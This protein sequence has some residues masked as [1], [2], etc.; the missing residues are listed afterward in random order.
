MKKITFVTKGGEKI[1]GYRNGDKVAYR[2]MWRNNKIEEYFRNCCG[3]VISENTAKFE[4]FEAQDLLHALGM[5]EVAEE[6]F[7][8]EKT[9]TISFVEGWE[10]K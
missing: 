2:D 10:K 8:K 9:I 1:E 5:H 4:T 7:K 3:K 6:I